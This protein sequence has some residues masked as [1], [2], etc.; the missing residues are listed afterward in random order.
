[1]NSL[2]P[3]RR[4]NRFAHPLT[5][6][7]ALLVATLACATMIAGEAR[8]Q[9]NSGYSQDA[10]T[11]L[12]LV[13]DYRAENGLAPVALEDTLTTAA[14]RH[15]EDQVKY[16]FFDHSTVESDY[17]APGSG[18][19]ERATQ[20]GYPAEYAVGEN[21]AYGY[22]SVERTF[23]GWV[24]SPSH[25]ANLLNPDWQVMGLGYDPDGDMWSQEFG[26]GTTSATQENPTSSEPSS[27][28]AAPS[29][30][31]PSDAPS[32]EE[33]APSE[34]DAES[35]SSEGEEAS[36]EDSSGSDDTAEEGGG[37]RTDEK[38]KPPT[39][40]GKAGDDAEVAAKKPA[41][42]DTRE[43][44]IEVADTEKADTEKA[45]EGEEG[46]SSPTTS[47]IESG[48]VAQKS[49]SGAEGGATV[50]TGKA[51]P[52]DSS[53]SAGEGEPKADQ[54]KKHAKAEADEAR[55][56]AKA[57][58]EKAKAAADKAKKKAEQA[59][60]EAMSKAEKAKQR[61][62]EQA[63]KAEKEA[64]KAEKESKEKAEQAKKQAKEQAEEALK[65][66]T[67]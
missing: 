21:I 31:A 37:E 30:A 56:K 54:V 57:A 15:S 9:E 6:L 39:S 55:E 66:A 63:E 28:E 48:F 40:T 5:W 8:A 1:M 33:A 25:N 23:E 58:T 7:C 13:N 50:V 32:E 24:N 20:E 62:E 59:K 12:K 18:P 35:T 65:A 3:T 19:Y 29:E 47:P 41:R 42:T 53:D 16:D 26:S 44:D 11:M 49:G 38:T 43:A 34:D 22:G 61:A 67:D 46:G 45:T 27:G 52:G 64:E 4:R 10:L 14:R 60:K 36:G 17:Y 2:T 51:A